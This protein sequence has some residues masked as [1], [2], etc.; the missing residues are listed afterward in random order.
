MGKER[1][2]ERSDNERNSHVRCFIKLVDR[3]FRIITDKG[4]GNLLQKFTPSSRKFRI[5]FESIMY[6]LCRV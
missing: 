2:R 5:I 4:K 6:V 1:E 3:C